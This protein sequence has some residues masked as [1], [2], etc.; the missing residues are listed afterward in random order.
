MLVIMYHNPFLI[1]L[2]TRY[3]QDRQKSIRVLGD[4]PLNGNWWEKLPCIDLLPSIDEVAEPHSPRWSGSDNPK[5]KC[6]TTNPQAK[7]RIYIKLNSKFQIQGCSFLL[8]F[9]CLT[10]GFLVSD[11]RLALFGYRCSPK[12]RLLQ[13]SSLTYVS[14][15]DSAL[16]VG[17]YWCYCLPGC[18]GRCLVGPMLVSGNLSPMPYTCIGSHPLIP[19]P[20][21]R[22]RIAVAQMG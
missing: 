22:H 6:K 11:L 2:I 19:R 21:D 16:V 9:R 17:V 7:H 10:F 14:P 20:Q 18:C 1:A 12:P 4:F 15:V 5:S 3:L 13:I 8:R